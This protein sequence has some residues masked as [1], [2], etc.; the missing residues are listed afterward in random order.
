[1]QVTLKVESLGKMLS[2]IEATSF[3][4]RSVANYATNK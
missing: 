1:M 3:T 2:E 4:K